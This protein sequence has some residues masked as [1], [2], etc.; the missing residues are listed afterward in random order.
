MMLIRRCL[1]SLLS[2]A[3]Y[4]RFIRLAIKSNTVEQKIGQIANKNIRISYTGGNELR[5][6]Y[7]NK[8]LIDAVRIS[9]LKKK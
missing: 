2:F 4:D 6:W 5:N 9:Q 8:N 3:N 1:P 7:Y